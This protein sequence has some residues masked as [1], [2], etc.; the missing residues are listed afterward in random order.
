[1][2]VNLNRFIGYI[3]I[4][5]IML[6]SAAVLRADVTG[7]V[8]GTVRDSS[9]AIVAGAKITITNAKTNLT[10]ETV[11]AADGSYRILALPAG[12]YRLTV[13]AAGFKTY[14]TTD[15]EV[16]VNDQLQVD[17]TLS[18]GSSTEVVSV[19]ANAVQV[20]TES[21]QLG[22]VIDSKKMLA[23]PL[24]GRSYLDLL[25]LQAGVVP[26]TSGSIQQDRPVSGG[27]STS[28]GN[29]SVNGQRETA[30]AFLVNGGD[31]SEG[32]NMGAGLVPNLDSIEEF[33][34][35]TN[36]FD[37]EYG[38]FSGAVMNAI[39]KSGTNSFHG[40]AFEF[41]RNEALNAHNYFDPSRGEFRRNQFGF[42]MGGP[43]WKNKL[44]WFSDYQGTRQTQGA[45][46]GSIQLPNAAQRDGTFDPTTFV[47][48]SGNPT[49]VKGGYWAQTLTSRLSTVTG[50][51]VS[52]GEPYATGSCNSTTWTS[53]TTTPNGCVF[54]GGVIPM[55]AWSKPSI[56]ILPY[57]P[58]GDP[59]TGLYSN[60]SQKNT[61]RDD[62]A[63]ERVDFINQ[64]TGNWSFYYHYDD[65]DSQTALTNGVS[66]PLPGFLTI[67]PQ[68]AQQFVISNT[69]TISTT[70]VNE[71]RFS[72]FRTA[73]ITDKPTSSQSLTSLGFM[74]NTGLGIFPSGPAGFPQTVPPL[75]F[76]NFYVGVNTLT[77]F[78]PNNTWHVSDG[79]SKLIGR[80]TL[81]FGGEFRYLQINER[82]T[83]APN[84][85]F[86][87]NAGPGGETGLD[88]ADFLLGA[89]VSYNQCSQQF[90]DSRTRYGGAYGEDTFKVNQ[91]LTLNLG[92]RW[93]VSMPWYDTQGKIET[94][95]PGQQST[96]FPTA[97]LSWVVPGDKGIPSTLAPT[98]YN[99][100]SPRLGL[101]YSPG[102]SD[103]VLGK[104]FGGPGKSS[105]RAAYGIYYT[106]IED[107]N[108]FYEVGDAP[109]GLY[110][111]SPNP[112]MFDQPFQTRA[113]G[114]SQTQR[115]PFTFP[116][117]GSPANKTIDYS[118]YLP[119][120]FSPG[121]DIHNRLPYAEH[122][123][124]SFQRELTKST[125]LTMAYVGTQ[126]HRLI[127]QYDA[128]PGDQA[129]CLQI[130]ALGGTNLSTGVTNTPTTPAC[131][132]NQEQATYSLPPGTTA[133]SSAYLTACPPGTPAGSTCINGTRDTL[134]PNFSQNNSRT[135]NIANSNYNAGEITL[136]R[137]ANDFT[138]LAAYTFSKGIDDSSG[139]GQWVNFANHRLSRSLSAY[140]ITHN[141]VVSYIWAM[142]FDR[143]FPK[144]TKYLTQGW[145]MNGI[146]RWSGGLPVALSESDDNSLT[147]SANT[148]VPNV[149]GKLVKLNPRHVSPLCIDPNTGLP[150]SGCFFAAS[151]FTAGPFGQFGNANRQYFHGPGLS[152]TDFGIS[153]RTNFNERFGCE[154]RA[155]FFN[156]FNHAQFM[157]PAGN[158]NNGQF[159]FVTSARD[160]RIGQ[161]SAKFYW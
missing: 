110:W 159:S 1:M 9:Q 19:E 8:Q 42:A 158:I 157:N 2:V 46:T 102:F 40:D 118:I 7:S 114:S 75:Y 106:S 39:T 112:V 137:K 78:Q 139:F 135:A 130:N 116:I 80:H 131:A 25:G 79:F 107:L 47:D 89:P 138:F 34:L 5:L 154:I 27:Y 69:K 87:F 56:G 133:P 68:R 13:T 126:G 134:G 84:G 61:V 94:I 88:W 150:T 145:T 97:P 93:E 91:R 128:N 49:T 121:Y 60:N 125:V 21:T 43:F 153:K 90:L 101:A 123:N 161:V 53:P 70:A 83:C 16:K 160:P 152:N 109:F 62:K 140:D 103:G 64:K 50:Q 146:T 148:D 96:Q 55:A 111:V 32:R 104:I 71:F 12:T 36:S 58:M 14:N 74:T 28:V 117:P 11:S 24:N 141:F 144:G 37:A 122:Y 66:N 29:L 100:F 147:G 143:L 129:L 108:L 48:G 38:K 73:T 98:R 35:I 113:D 54:P 23:L 156:I 22:D 57:I 3:S 76:T 142:P 124:L 10:Q 44:F 63:G 136:E 99:N 72:F 20:Q 6:G 86:S 115:F 65:S 30:N 41:L 155:E 151:S 95:V 132:P 51:T 119:L 81:K 149:A 85:D 26:V 127:A 33:R 92:V 18:V 52:S 105:I 15:I 67:T 77:T 17:V 45:S 120:S 31:V 4:V 59:T 82:N